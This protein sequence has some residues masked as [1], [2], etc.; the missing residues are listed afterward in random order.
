M[1]AYVRSL[2]FKLVLIVILKILFL[3]ALWYLVLRHQS[4]HIDATHMTERF[5]SSPSSS[6]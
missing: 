3:V 6:P 4:V 2:G 1:I 5:L